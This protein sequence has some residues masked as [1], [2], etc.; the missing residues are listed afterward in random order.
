MTVN[1]LRVT[2]V[3]PP[4]TPLVT[5]TVR[6]GTHRER[7]DSLTIT[8]HDARHEPKTHRL[9]R[10]DDGQPVIAGDARHPVQKTRFSPFEPFLSSDFDP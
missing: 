3:S 6:R 8:E 2:A 1:P 9:P 7:H 5:V 10:C 4:E